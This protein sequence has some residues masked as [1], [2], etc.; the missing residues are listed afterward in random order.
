MPSSLVLRAVRALFACSALLTLAPQG[1]S[2][3]RTSSSTT[4]S[5]I[6]T[7]SSTT[8]AGSSVATAGPPPDVYLNVPNLSVGRIELN[9]DNL[10]ADIN[11]NANVASLVTINA[12]IALSVQNINLTIEDVQAE[13]ELVV[14]L[15]N[16]VEIV[17][18]VFESLD[19]NPLLISTLSNATNLL[20]PVI[21]AVDGLLGTVTQGGTTISFVVDNFGNIVQQVA[22]ANGNPVS[23]IVGNYLTNMTDTGVSQTLQNGLISRQYSYTPLNALVNIVFNAAGQ[24]VQASVVKGSTTPGGSSTVPGSSSTVA[25]RPSSTSSISSSRTGAR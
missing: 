19:L 14:R 15:G 17:N 20:Q 3:Q 22:G 7:T 1:I 11:L 8:A 4:S 10:Q 2:A 23:S 16:L 9:V 25:P 6:R 13:L 18:R 24:V 21:G 5:T 12:G